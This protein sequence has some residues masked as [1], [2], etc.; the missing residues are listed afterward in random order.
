MH[1]MLHSMIHI[2]NYPCLKENL[3]PEENW[4]LM[5]TDIWMKRGIIFCHIF[6]WTVFWF[7]INNH[8]IHCLKGFEMGTREG[9][10]I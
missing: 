7:H 9:L 1:A 4:M 2:T 10:R 6:V 3:I 8:L 5:F